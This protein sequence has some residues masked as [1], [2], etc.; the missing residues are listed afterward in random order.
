MRLEVAGDGGGQ[1]AEATGD[2]VLAVL[3]QV[4]R[5]R[6]KLIASEAIRDHIVDQLCGGRW[7]T[8]GKAQ[9]RL[10]GSDDCRDKA[11]CRADD[12]FASSC[13]LVRD[14]DPLSLTD[15]HFLKQLGRDTTHFAI[16]LSASGLEVSDYEKANLPDVADYLFDIVQEMGTSPPD[17]DA[18]ATRTLV[19]ASV[20]GDPALPKTVL[21]QI[22]AMDAVQK[23]KTELAKLDLTGA[24]EL[25]DKA[26]EELARLHAARI[27]PARARMGLRAQ[28]R[29]R[30]N[31]SSSSSVPANVSMALDLRRARP[32]ATP[33]LTVARQVARSTADVSTSS[34]V[35]VEEDSSEMRFGHPCLCPSRHTPVSATR[36]RA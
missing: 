19:L 32:C 1:V 25:K 16:R 4:V 36:H 26:C 17:I 8:V 31:R 20:V 22:R 5:D 23:L 6:A 15:T 2:Q 21:D 7:L 10:G 27:D 29:G 3:A 13:R 34:L 12:V 33:L 9:I 11:I 14:P 18:I 24:C 30:R 35:D 28:D